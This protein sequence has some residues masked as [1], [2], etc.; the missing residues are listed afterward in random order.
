[1][2]SFPSYP[3]AGAEWR[4]EECAEQS[5]AIVLQEFDQLGF[6]HQATQLDE[7]S[8][9]GA[10]FLNPVACVSPA[11]GEHESIPEYDQALELSR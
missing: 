10:S 1:M 6:L 7:L 5:C 8:C 4:F 3:F 9:P 2:A 11:L